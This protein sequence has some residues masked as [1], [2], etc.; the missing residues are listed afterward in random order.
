MRDLCGVL[1]VPIGGAITFVTSGLPFGFAITSCPSTHIF[2]YPH[3]GISVVN[4]FAAEQP[5]EPGITHVCLVDPSMDAEAHEIEVAAEL[6]APRGAFV[7]VYSNAGA[8]VRDV[9]EM[10][11]WFPY[12]LLLISTHCGDPDGYRWTYEFKDSEGHDRRLVIDI[13]LM[14]EI[15]TTRVFCQ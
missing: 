9:G 13:A 1:P 15:P 6:L 5:G 8:N 2:S 12:D 11:E 14:S 4:G 10:M 7:R 3:M